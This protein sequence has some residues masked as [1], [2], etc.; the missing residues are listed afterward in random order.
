MVTSYQFQFL[1]RFL[2][3]VLEQLNVLNKTFQHRQ[4]DLAAVQGQIRRTATH[5]NTR[6]VDC[7]DNFGGGQSENL[8]PFIAGFVARHSPPL[9]SSRAP[10]VAPYCHALP[11]APRCLAVRLPRPPSTYYAVAACHA[12]RPAAPPAHLPCALPRP[13]APCCEPTARPA[14]R[15]PSRHDV[16]FIVCP[17]IAPAAHLPRACRPRLQLR[18]PTVPTA[19]LSPC[20]QLLPA[21]APLG[22]VP[23]AS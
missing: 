4:I 6:Y 11:R 1:L 20:L 10:T 23:T 18:L 14:A 19:R 7:G 15:P 13:A 8:S 5:I 3:D 16:A 22:H 9:A 12:A 2:A 21:A 17:A